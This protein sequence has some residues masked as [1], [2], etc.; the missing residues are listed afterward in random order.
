[1]RFY[2]YFWCLILVLGLGVRFGLVWLQPS[3]LTSDNDG[4]LA[5]ARP[6]A[7]GRGFLG[8]YSHQP[9][10]F[11]PPGYP[12]VIAALLAAG[13]AAPVAVMLINT[14]ASVVIICLSR[15]LGMQAGLSPGFALLSALIVALD[16]LLVRYSVLP[17]TEVPCAAVLLAAVVLG[18]KAVEAGPARKLASAVFSG[19]L[20]GI[21]MLIRPI[22]LISCVFVSFDGLRQALTRSSPG[23][24]FASSLGLAILPAMVAGL[25][26]IPWVVRNAMHF[27]AF[28]PATTHGG[29]TLA[30]GN[31]PDF[32]RDV[33]NGPD[34][35]PWEGGALDAWQQRMI[36][37]SKQDGLP[38]ADEPAMD[39]WYYEQ[40]TAAITA[41]PLSFLKATW[42]RLTRFW[43]I[44]TAES[45]GPRW[46]SA[47]T[48][49]WYSVLWLG[50][51]MERMAAWQV[52]KTVGR[53]RVA[54]L[55]L[56]VL[57]FMLMHAVYWTDARMRAPLMPVL[58]VLSLIGWQS[59]VGSL[60]RLRRTN[61]RSST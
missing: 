50:L 61:E 55:W 37:Q 30:L 60:A 19:L 4:Y 48:G 16:P 23:R 49:L 46:I 59:A 57:S 40:A 27:R 28:I 44:T 42:L 24:S 31:N 29:Y 52:R 25:L 17:M 9:T 3:D 35:F 51:L 45:M 32:Y 22:V 12:M 38:Q 47:S 33:I 18:R 56:V 6:V 5:H 41:D 1:M 36:A 26:L 8:P 39:A 15:T 10:A 53:S 2:R 58:V 13:V 11:R 7:E 54:D 21:G 20:F 14:V 34:A 43:A